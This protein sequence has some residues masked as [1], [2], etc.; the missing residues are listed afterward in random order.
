M[1]AGRFNRQFETYDQWRQ[2]LLAETARF[3]EWGL[4]HPDEVEWIPRH[5]VGKGGFSERAKRLFWAI[6]L[7]SDRM[8]D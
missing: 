7:S 5:P 8:P 6:V 1:R 4:E 2:R 3:I